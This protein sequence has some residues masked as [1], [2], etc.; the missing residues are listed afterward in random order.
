MQITLRSVL[1]RNFLVTSDPIKLSGPVIKWPKTR[2]TS[3]KL[4]V[5]SFIC[6]KILHFLKYTGTGNQQI[7]NKKQKIVNKEN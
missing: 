7:L 3:N 5:V 4:P 6:L 1:I 2:T